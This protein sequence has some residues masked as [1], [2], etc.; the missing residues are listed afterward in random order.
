MKHIDRQE[1]E[2]IVLKC[3]E[4]GRV[5]FLILYSLPLMCCYGI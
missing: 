3:P 2:L 4:S 5:N 1:T